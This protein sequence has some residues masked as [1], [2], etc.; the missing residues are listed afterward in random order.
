[1]V[2]LAAG[3]SVPYAYIPVSHLRKKN[4]LFLLLKPLFSFV[5]MFHSSPGPEA[6][7]WRLSSVCHLPTGWPVLCRNLPGRTRLRL[8]CRSLR[9][10]GECAPV[11][12]QLLQQRLP[13]AAVLPTAAAAVV[14]PAKL[15]VNVANISCNF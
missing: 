10:A 4:V 15:V 13:T 1:M 11:L 6:C 5:G 9:V 14:P 7:Y 8:S 2:S 3:A 12:R